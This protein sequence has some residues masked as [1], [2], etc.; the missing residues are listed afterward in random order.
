MF[1]D[2]SAIVALIADEPDRAEIYRK[3]QSSKRRTMSALSAYEATLALMRI[4]KI[5]P[6]QAWQLVDTFRKSFAIKSYPI[7]TDLAKDALNAFVKFG[8]G[9]HLAK[10]NMGDCFS[11]ACAKRSKQP[12]LFKGDDFNKTD[13]DCL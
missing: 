7:E 6:E 5:T 8:K 2:A 10:L 3:L 12:L 1:I 13:V 11:Y 9:N 4:K